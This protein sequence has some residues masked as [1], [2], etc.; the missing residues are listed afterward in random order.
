MTKSMITESSRMARGLIPPEQ[1]V[2]SRCICWRGQAP[3][4]SRTRSGWFAISDSLGRDWLSGVF[5]ALVSNSLMII[6][7]VFAQH[8]YIEM[9]GFLMSDVASYGSP[10]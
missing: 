4:G 1:L 9:L 3:V 5:F 2:G 7:I 10:L 8:V 6:R